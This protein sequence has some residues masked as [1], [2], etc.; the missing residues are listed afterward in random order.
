MYGTLNF[1]NGMY[2]KDS[3]IQHVE[4]CKFLFILVIAQFRLQFAI[5]TISIV[6]D[7][8]NT[9]T[10]YRTHASSNLS[11]PAALSVA[12]PCSCSSMRWEAPPRP[13]GSGWACR[14]GGWIFLLVVAAS[15]GVR[16][17][18]LRERP[19]GREAP[20]PWRRTSASPLP[21]WIVDLVREDRKEPRG[22]RR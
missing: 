2:V 12:V 3:T 13:W 21:G 16:G 19:G 18:R 11:F 6:F 17:R 4:L 1:L 14:Q 10:I 20:C 9:S 7:V 15:P 5:Y 22:R 8:S